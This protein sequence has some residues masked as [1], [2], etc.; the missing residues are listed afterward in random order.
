[1]LWL[2][3][4]I[5]IFLFTAFCIGLGIGWWIWG[6]GDDTPPDHTGADPAMGTLNTDYDPAAEALPARAPER[7]QE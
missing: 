4:H 1:M 7:S 5:W 6:A 3:A 2:A